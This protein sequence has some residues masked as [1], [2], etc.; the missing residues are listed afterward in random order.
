MPLTHWEFLGVHIIFKTLQGQ[1]E[2]TKET[3]TFGLMVQKILFDIST[4]I[5][6]AALKKLDLPTFV[7][8]HIA[9]S[10]LSL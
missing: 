1:S 7:L 3:P 8:P 9:I 5:M 4:S 2:V 6:V 10:I